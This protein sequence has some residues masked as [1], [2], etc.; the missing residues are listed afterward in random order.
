V[1]RRGVS[2]PSEKEKRPKEPNGP[3]QE[4]ALPPRGKFQ[5]GHDDHGGKSPAPARR[6]P[7]EALGASPIVALEPVAECFRQVGE[8]TRFPGTEQEPNQN[9]RDKIPRPPCRDSEE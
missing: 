3:E 2:E 8:T 6:Q 5:N 9:Q 1:L 7:G 4:K